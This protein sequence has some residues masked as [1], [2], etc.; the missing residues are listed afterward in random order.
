MEASRQIKTV[1]D[2]LFVRL[3]QTAWP[4]LPKPFETRINQFADTARK[5]SIVTDIAVAVA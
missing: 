4:R 1:G 3:A 5:Y 2:P